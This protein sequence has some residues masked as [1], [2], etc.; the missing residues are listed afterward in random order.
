[1]PAALMRP[2][3]LFS[4][5]LPVSWPRAADADTRPGSVPIGMGCSITAICLIR[6]RIPSDG[7]TGTESLGWQQRGG[8]RGTSASRWQQQRIAVSGSATGT[9]GLRTAAVLPAGGE[10]RRPRQVPGEGLGMGSL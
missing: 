8:H 2:R 6:I 1:M 10:K 9:S 3:S 5:C 4:R 7:C